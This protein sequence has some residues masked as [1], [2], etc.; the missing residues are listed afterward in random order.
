MFGPQRLT[1]KELAA[2]LGVSP[3]TV[4]QWRVHGGGPAYLK[5]GVSVRYDLATVEAW[6]RAQTRSHTADPGPAAA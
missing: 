6:E 1:E 4:Q 2:R 5:L 3:R